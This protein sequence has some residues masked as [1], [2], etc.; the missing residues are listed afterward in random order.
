[1]SYSELYRKCEVIAA[2]LLSLGLKK[3]DRIG[4]YSPNNYEWILVQYAASMADLILVNINPAY[5]EHELEYCLKKGKLFFTALS[6][7]Y[8]F[9]DLV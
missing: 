3:G 5:Q 6:F 4:I 9:Y 1:L 8:S 7:I 2:G